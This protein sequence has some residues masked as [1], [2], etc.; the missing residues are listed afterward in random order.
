MY[1]DNPKEVNV[2]FC[3][4]PVLIFGN[5]NIRDCAGKAAVMYGPV[6][7]CAEKCD[8]DFVMHNIYLGS[9]LNANFVPMNEL[10][11]N[12]LCVDGFEL[13][14]TNDLYSECCG[15]FEKIKLKLI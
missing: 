13:K 15:E 3:M 1:I 9:E 12:Y 5:A 7:Y 2:D 6:V 4:K 14:K 8:N 11:C 10:N